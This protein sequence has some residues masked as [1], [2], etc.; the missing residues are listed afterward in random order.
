MNAKIMEGLVG[1]R[2]STDLMNTP[3]RVFEEAERRGDT[4]V[5]ER[6]MGYAGDMAE[7]AADYQTKADQGMEED[8]KKTEEEAKAQQEEAIKKRREEREK[9][10]EKLRENGKSDPSASNLVALAKLYG[11]SAVELLEGL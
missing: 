2:T 1:A 10:E 9:T 5:M 8:A 11:L 4:A 7:K 6:A 3:M